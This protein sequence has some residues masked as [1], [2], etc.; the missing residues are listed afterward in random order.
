MPLTKVS[1]TPA[2]VKVVVT[3]RYCFA[4]GC[5]ELILIYHQKSIAVHFLIIVGADADLISKLTDG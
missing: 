2:G 3:R 4:L 1:I 5:Q